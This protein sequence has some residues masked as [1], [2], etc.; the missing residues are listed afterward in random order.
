MVFANAFLL[1][2]SVKR[3]FPAE[4][5][6]FVHFES[7]GCVL[8][9]LHGVVVALFALRTS[10]G[11]LHSHFG[12]S[13]FYCCLPHSDRAYLKIYTQKQGKKINPAKEV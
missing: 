9:V 7:V 11:D 1:G 13:V 3:V 8:L 2:L 6:V 4:S 12:T 10:K 5:A